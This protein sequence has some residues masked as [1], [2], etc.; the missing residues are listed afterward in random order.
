MVLFTFYDVLHNFS[1]VG[2]VVH[3]LVAVSSAQRWGGSV[4]HLGANGPS[5]DGYPR[6]SIS[7]EG[8]AALQGGDGGRHGL[9]ADGQAVIGLSV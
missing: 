3:Q 4:G 5:F 6:A 7:L 8:W 1:D 2:D 9:Q